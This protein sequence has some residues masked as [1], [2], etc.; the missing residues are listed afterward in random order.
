MLDVVVIGAGF[1][2]LYSIHKLTRAGLR[3]AGYEKGGDVGG[4]W[5][6]NRYP[7]ARCDCESHVYSYGF[8]DELQQE[9][10][11]T[12]RYSEQPEILQY[13]GHVA[14]RFDLRRHIRFNTT[15]L[16]AIFLESENC[17]QIETSDGDRVFSR[18]IVAAAGGISAVQ[19]P[20]FP[21]FERFAGRS[22]YTAQWPHEGADL[23]GKRVGIIGTGA[24]GVQCVSTLAPQVQHLTVFQRTANWV[25]PVW[26]GPTDPAVDR[27]VKAE[28]PHLRR[29]SLDTAGGFPFDL[30]EGSALS[31]SAEERAAIY[32]RAWKLGGVMFMSRSFNDLLVNREANETAAEFVRAYI[33]GT[34]KDPAVAE[35]LIP[36][37]HPIGTKRP[38]MDDKYYETFNRDNVTLV[39]LRK[40]PLIE[41][42]PEGIRT[43]AGVHELDVVIFATGFDTITGALTRIDIRGREGR[44]LAAKWSTGAQ[45]Y[46][47]LAMAGFPNLFTITGPL[48]PS[49][50]ANM[51]T[52][53]EQHVDWIT[54][55]LLFMREHGYG[56]VEPTAAAEEEWTR[57][58]MEVAAGSL[59]PL[60]NSWY[61]GCNVPGKPRVFG[62]YVGG[63]GHYRRKCDQV[64]SAGYEGFLFD[65]AAHGAPTA[66]R[67]GTP[68]QAHASHA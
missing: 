46:L 45:T 32:Q 42:V 38:P 47:G 65:G 27:R 12:L 6:W 49:V 24:S 33:R 11:W 23:A 66:A 20:T 53:I 59:F 41:F 8:S 54:D 25:F 31:V 13:L 40:S 15:V 34:V 14:D 62:V 4:V 56:V 1:A 44:S 3:V 55:C 63:F 18:F 5:Y 36:V 43:S 39:D 37:D 22:Y 26:N 7:G 17:W 29:A 68:S 61:L 60:A 48:S 21:G 67:A 28:Y 30:V 35:T 58:S 51:P 19:R 10:N 50:L 16:A 64:A 57:H 2:G 9:W 52:A